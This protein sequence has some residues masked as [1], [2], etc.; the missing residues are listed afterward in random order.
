MRWTGTF[1]GPFSFI[2]LEGVPPTGRR[3]DVEHAHAFRVSD[4]KIA[5][6]WAIRDDLTMRNQLLDGLPR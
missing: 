1:R 6:H 2:G 5:E 3:F 4:D